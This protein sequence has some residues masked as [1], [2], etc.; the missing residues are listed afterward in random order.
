MLFCARNIIARLFWESSFPRKHHIVIPANA[1]HR[2]S[3]ESITSSFPR[4]HHI[5][6]PANAPHRHSRESGNPASFVRTPLDPR[7]RGDDES[8][9]EQAIILR[10]ATTL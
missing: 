10:S 9:V 2:H 7:F 5:V 1:P 4:T 6:I 3:R 8:L